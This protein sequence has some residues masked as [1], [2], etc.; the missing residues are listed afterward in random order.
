V[1][2]STQSSNNYHSE[3][4]VWLVMRAQGAFNRMDIPAWRTGELP[5]PPGTLRLNAAGVA[6]LGSA[7]LAVYTERQPCPTCSP[8]LN[9]VLVNGT[10]VYW[11]F[12]YPGAETK[13]HKHSDDD[14]ASNALLA[15]SNS[16]TYEQNMRDH[17]RDYR[18]EGNSGLRSA[19]RD[20]RG[21]QHTATLPPLVAAQRRLEALYAPEVTA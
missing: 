13:K 21:S 3:K 5:L 8:F 10:T 4:E 2:L 15:I 18:K 16:K 14:I 1:L 17:Q 7:I 12:P 19:L 11:H 9:D 20:V 6:G